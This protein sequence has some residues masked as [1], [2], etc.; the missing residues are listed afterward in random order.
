MS[1]ENLLVLST[2]HIDPKTAELLNAG[3][4]LDIVSL[5]KHEYGWVLPRGAIDSMVI[6]GDDVPACFVAIATRAKQLDCTWIVLDCDADCDDT[7]Q[8]WEW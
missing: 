5:G 8:K 1:I 2:A 3:E 6:D 4:N 7:L